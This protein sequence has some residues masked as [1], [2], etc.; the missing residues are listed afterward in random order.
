MC[1]VVVSTKLWLFFY[2]DPIVDWMETNMD[3]C[4]EQ[5]L[6]VPEWALKCLEDDPD[7]MIEGI[8]DLGF[9]NR[10]DWRLLKMI[11]EIGKDALGGQFKIAEISGNRYSIDSDDFS[12]FIRTPDQFTWIYV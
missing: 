2:L 1:R 7:F 5:K 3:F 8:V 6:S 9:G 12:E 11:D 10:H 4:K